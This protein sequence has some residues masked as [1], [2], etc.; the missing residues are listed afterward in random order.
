MTAIPIKSPATHDATLR[1]VY[2]TGT[3]ATRRATAARRCVCGRATATA[4]VWGLPMCHNCAAKTC[5]LKAL[6]AGVCV[7]TEYLFA[8]C[9]LAQW[10]R[11]GRS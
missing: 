4:T 1:G 11:G 2:E 10:L 8:V 5:G 3:P 6:P 7:G 9:I